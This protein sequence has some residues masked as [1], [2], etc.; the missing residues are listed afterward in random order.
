MF[1]KL[2]RPHGRDDPGE[3]RRPERDS[4][5]PEI[6]QPGKKSPALEAR[7]GS[8]RPQGGKA[9]A[10]QLFVRERQEREKRTRESSEKIKKQIDES[11]HSKAFTGSTISGSQQSPL[12]LRPARNPLDGRQHQS[13]ELARRAPPEPE[14]VYVPRGV[15]LPEAS[16]ALLKPRVEGYNENVFDALDAQVRAHLVVQASKLI[17]HAQPDAHRAETFCKLLV[18]GLYCAKFLARSACLFAPQK[19]FLPNYEVPA[20]HQNRKKR[21]LFFEPLY[22]LAIPNPGFAADSDAGEPEYFLRPQAAQF[23]GRLAEHWELVVFSSRKAEQLSA[24]VA[25]LDPLKTAIRFVLDR[26]HCSITQQKKCVKD[27]AT[28]QNV[29]PDSALILDYKPQNVAFSL[30]HALL[31][32]HWNGAEDDCELLP[33][34]L[35]RLEHLAQQ[36]DL[37][38]ALRQA[39]QYPELL[40]QIYKLPTTPN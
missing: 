27:L 39:T 32:L 29:A 19:V 22:T 40:A 10:L 7:R 18:N 16:G 17:C 8:F 36:P 6:A 4:E 3:D 20:R 21:T 14:A 24:L 28:V 12:R 30:D 23:V 34:L 31:V 37:L 38:G 11:V 15:R 9:D 2:K 1:V 26:R 5:L 35:A 13:V 33:G 25:A